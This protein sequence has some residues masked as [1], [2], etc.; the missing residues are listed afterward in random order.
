VELLTDCIEVV[1]PVAEAVIDPFMGSGSTGVAA[2]Q[3]GRRFIGIEADA[4]HFETACRRLQAAHDSPRL[5]VAPPA[6]VQDPL[7][8]QTP[9]RGD[10]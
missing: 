6:P 5:F 10:G 4:D 7:F 3:S 8:G 2:L 9:E 1:A